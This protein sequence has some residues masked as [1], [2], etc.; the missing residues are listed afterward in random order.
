M[1]NTSQEWIIGNRR[2][3]LLNGHLQYAFEQSS[4]MKPIAQYYAFNIMIMLSKCC[5]ITV[6]CYFT[7]CSIRVSRS[8]CCKACL[9]PNYLATL[10]V[11]NSNDIKANSLTNTLWSLVKF[12][13]WAYYVCIMPDGFGCLLCLVLF[14]HNRLEPINFYYIQHYMDRKNKSVRKPIKK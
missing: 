13:N 14:Q 8:G 9:T 12:E 11:F 10:L 4:K 1:H 3:Q 2:P 5:L 6:F 7:D